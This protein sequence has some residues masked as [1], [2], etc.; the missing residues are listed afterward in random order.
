VSEKPESPLYIAVAEDNPADVYL[1]REALSSR[2]I[3]CEL[4]LLTDGDQAVKFVRGLAD[5]PALPC[6]DLLLLDMHLP[7]RDGAE[8]LRSVRC[9]SRCERLPVIIFTSSIDPVDSQSVAGDRAA[10]YF[11]KPA[12]L[13][14]FMKLGDL[15]RAVT[16]G[17]DGWKPPE[18]L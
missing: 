10:R 17:E 5:N 13:D 6:P 4:E 9:S 1:V 7:K 2:G 3:E 14:E 15:V 8:V 16:R 18:E 12:S 11:R